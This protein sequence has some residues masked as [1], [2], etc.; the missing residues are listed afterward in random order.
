[1]LYIFG[2][3]YNEYGCN[4]LVKVKISIWF[5]LWD[6]LL[7]LSIMKVVKDGS[8]YCMFFIVDRVLDYLW[9]CLCNIIDVLNRKNFIVYFNVV[10]IVACVM[11][12]LF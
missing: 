6:I 2:I 9:R 12:I 3:R 10:K 8:L 5:Y 4:M 1:M 11:C 7:K